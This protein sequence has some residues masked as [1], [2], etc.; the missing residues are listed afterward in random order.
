MRE[1]A[2]AYICP[3]ARDTHDPVAHPQGFC[4]RMRCAG[5]VGRTHFFDNTCKLDTPCHL[6]QLLCRSRRGSQSATTSIASDPLVTFL[7]QD[8]IGIVCPGLL[9]KKKPC[10]GGSTRTF[11]DFPKLLCMVLCRKGTW[12]WSGASSLQAA[13]ASLLALHPHFSL[14]VRHSSPHPFLVC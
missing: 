12:V 14:F 7:Q 8:M 9:A 10:C 13:D 11:G 3:K 5:I 2:C 4:R 1:K 6:E